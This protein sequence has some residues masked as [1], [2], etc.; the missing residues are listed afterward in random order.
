MN[1][2]SVVKTFM[3]ALLVLCGMLAMTGLF[4][5]VVPGAN[6]SIHWYFSPIT[7][8]FSDSGPL[9]I[10][11]IVFLLIIGGALH[12]LKTTGLMEGVIIATA[13]KYQEKE[14]VL[15]SVLV[16]VFMA[17]GAFVGVFEEVVPLVPL[18][19]LLSKGM[20]W[21]D[22]TGLGISILAC[23]LGFAAAV[24]NPFTIG[25]AQELAE[26]PLFSGAVLRIFV[27]KSVYMI[28]LGFLWGHIKK[29]RTPIRK[30]VL[31]VE[32]KGQ[33]PKKAYI[34]FSSSMILMGCFIAT[35]PFISILRDLSLPIIALIF[36]VTAMGVGQLVK[37]NMKWI[38]KQYAIGARDMAPAIVLILIATGIKHIM[39]E[40]H[41]LD[42]ILSRV[43]NNIDQ[44]SIWCYRNDFSIGSLLE[45]F[46]RFR[47]R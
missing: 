27:F 31:A 40:G 20:G 9:I 8:L 12:I 30:D 39:I 42:Y 15:L 43:S 1:K 10:A 28:L 17:M 6:P 32:P 45:F 3:S 23:S 19:I 18:V 46:Y 11:I 37:G 47:K 35:S 7:V 4:T 44:F 21:D 25:V 22:M 34:F 41:I 29:T 26:V 38:A 36:F 13:K 2:N 5:R 24:T 33:I 16:L 14:F